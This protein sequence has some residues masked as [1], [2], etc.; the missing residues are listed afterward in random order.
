M[1]KASRVHTINYIK[2]HDK[3][4]ISS[5]EV[6]GDNYKWKFIIIAETGIYLATGK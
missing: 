4:R 1:W 5:A 6:K 3:V 2:T